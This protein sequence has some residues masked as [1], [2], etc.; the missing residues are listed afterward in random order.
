[1]ESVPTTVN[2]LAV[3]ST[4]M[5]GADSTLANALAANDSSNKEDKNPLQSAKSVTD[6]A[7]SLQTS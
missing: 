4:S 6:I 7:L 5:D 2:I 1:M 3:S